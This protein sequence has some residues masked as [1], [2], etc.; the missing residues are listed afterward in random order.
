MVRRIFE[1]RMF[2]QACA[3]LIAVLATAGQ[4][5]HADSEKSFDPGP[6]VDELIATMD[7]EP[8]PFYA[9]PAEFYAEKL[10]ISEQRPGV[11]TFVEECATL[12]AIPLF[13]LSRRK[14][15]RLFI[16]ISFDGLL[17]IHARR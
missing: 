3:V 17:G 1:N 16:G 12:N 9:E 2:V 15:R 6:I 10:E 5:V 8:S 13:E 7:V 14:D 11:M 4:Q